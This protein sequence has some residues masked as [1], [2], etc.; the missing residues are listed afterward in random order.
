MT[1]FNYGSIRNQQDLFNNYNK[2]IIITVA[3][4]P[5]CANNGPG[6]APVIAQPNPNNKPP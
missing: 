2:V 5:I 4:E 6:Q 3:P 1:S